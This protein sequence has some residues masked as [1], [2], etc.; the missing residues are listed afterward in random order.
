VSQEPALEPQLGDGPEHLAACH[1]PMAEG[2]S[3]TEFRPTIGATERIIESAG[4]LAPDIGG[5]ADGGNGA[6][7]GN[8]DA[9]PTSREGGKA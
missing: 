6:G 5:L 1:R 7:G 9:L 4:I 3:L 8:I 2:E